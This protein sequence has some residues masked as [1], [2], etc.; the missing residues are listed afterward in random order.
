MIVV[1]IATVIVNVMMA[2]SL[3]V[4]AKLHRGV[5]QPGSTRCPANRKLHGGKRK[6]DS[7]NKMYYADLKKNGGGNEHGNL[8]KPVC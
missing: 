1:M 4:H 8:L 5:R 7:Q 2:V 3:A 6:S